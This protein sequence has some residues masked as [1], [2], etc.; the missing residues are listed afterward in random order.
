MKPN[1]K[2][3]VETRLPSAQLLQIPMFK[4][5][6]IAKSPD[7]NGSGLLHFMISDLFSGG[8]SAIRLNVRRSI[9]SYALRSLL[10]QTSAVLQ[11]AL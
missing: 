4:Q 10:Y 2:K 6:R 1:C 3:I 8:L 5:Q 7:P 11:E 9:N